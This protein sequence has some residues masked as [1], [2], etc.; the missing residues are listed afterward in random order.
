MA[1]FRILGVWLRSAALVTGMACLATPAMQAVAGVDLPKL[2]RG[3]GEQ[4]VEDVD[5]IRRLH[6]ALLKHQ[7]DDTL[8]RGIRTT[9]HSLKKCVECH[10]SEQTGSVA[11][12]KQDFCVA[13]HSYAAVK[14][15]CWDCHA[16]KP[17]RKPVRQAGALG[18]ASHPTPLWHGASGV[19]K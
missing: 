1:S 16:T 17:A 13:C 9:R 7:R 11:A 3:K 5:T 12:S 4:C 19:I 6:P 14:L 18:G 10:A 2:E 8:R 15:D